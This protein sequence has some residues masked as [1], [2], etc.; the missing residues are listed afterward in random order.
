MRGYGG[1]KKVGN[2]D[3]IRSLEF[4]LLGMARGSKR[5]IFTVDRANTNANIEFLF[6]EGRVDRL[7][8]GGRGRE[9]R[10]VFYET[11]DGKLKIEQRK[12]M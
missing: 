3:N 10:K 8:G 11:V 1:R 5:R 2:V 9:E 4:S 6:R 7:T 12:D